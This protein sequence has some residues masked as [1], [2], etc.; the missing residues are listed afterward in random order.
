MEHFVA[1]EAVHFPSFRPPRRVYLDLIGNVSR[2]G[3]VSEHS[4]ALQ[5]PAVT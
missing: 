2:P 1:E 5:K 4:G 3:V